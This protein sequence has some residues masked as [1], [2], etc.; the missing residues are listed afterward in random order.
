L[1]KLDEFVLAGAYIFGGLECPKKKKK[2]LREGTM[3]DTNRKKNADACKDDFG[4]REY[5]REQILG[6]R[7]RNKTDSDT[8]EADTLAKGGRECVDDVDGCDEPTIIALL[9]WD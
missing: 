5:L 2:S 9:L 3:K 4:K 8:H 1:K 6:S 7:S